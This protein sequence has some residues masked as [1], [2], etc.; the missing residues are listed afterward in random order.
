VKLGLGIWEK[1]KGTKGQRGRAEGICFS[2]AEGCSKSA[3]GQPGAGAGLAGVRRDG[4]ESRRRRAP[5]RRHRAP[6]AQCRTANVRGEA[7]RGRPTASSSRSPGGAHVSHGWERRATERCSATE[8][9]GFFTQYMYPCW[10]GPKVCLAIPVQP[11]RSASGAM[12]IGSRSVCCISTKSIV[13]S[14]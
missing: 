10:A 6:A 1:T 7:T 8:A 2:P 4:V 5:G 3:K 14:T 11:T 9:N 13:T 12:V